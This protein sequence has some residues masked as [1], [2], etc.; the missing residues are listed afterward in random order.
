MWHEQWFEGLEEASRYYFNDHNPDGMIAHLEPLHNMVEAVSATGF[1]LTRNFL[2][3]LQG[4]KTARETSFAQVFG[5]DLHEAREACRRYRIYGE[6]RDLEKAW[7]IYYGVFTRIKKQLET[8]TTLDLQFVSPELLKARNLQLAVPGT[9][10]AGK[11][12]VTIA[13]FVP[14]LTVIPSKQRPRRLAIKGSDH[15]DYHFVLKGASLSPITIP[16]KY[17]TP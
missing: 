3:L 9:Y 11:P 17:L 13:S 7:E 10:Q 15:K 8:L 16:R 6:V 12:I 4:P 1:C 14:K 2:T 5:R